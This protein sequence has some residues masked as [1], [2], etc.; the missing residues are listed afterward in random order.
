MSKFNIKPYQKD[1]IKLCKKYKVQELY[2]VG[3]A[4]RNDFNPT[5]S[6]IDFLIEFLLGASILNEVP[7]LNTKLEELLN[8]KVDFIHQDGIENPYLKASLDEDKIKLF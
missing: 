7:K 8:R 3:S 5:T 6:D 2:L 1:I 4:A